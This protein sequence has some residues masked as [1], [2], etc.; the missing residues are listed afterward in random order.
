MLLLIAHD[1]LRKKIQELGSIR[2][3]PQLAYSPG[4]EPSDHHLFRSMAHFLSGKHFHNIHDVEL[5][6]QDYLYLASKPKEFFLWGILDTASHWCKPIEHNGV[7]LK[8]KLLCS[9]LYTR[10]Y[11][12]PE[13][14]NNFESL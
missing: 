8:I 3:M 1:Q 12:L 2:L 11:Q 9:C 14:G 13:N 4:L 6:V 7:I 5:G 10:F